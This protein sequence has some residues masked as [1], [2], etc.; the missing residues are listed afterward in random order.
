MQ[1]SYDREW[2]E[3]CWI[4]FPIANNTEED[5]DDDDNDSSG[6]NGIYYEVIVGHLDSSVSEVCD[7]WSWSHEFKSYI[8][9]RI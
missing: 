7:S 6:N 1:S 4:L 5:D 9:G 8:G 2:E 3:W